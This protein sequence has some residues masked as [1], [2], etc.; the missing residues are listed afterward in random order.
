MMKLLAL[1]LLTAAALIVLP[2]RARADGSWLDSSPPAQW[3]QPGMAIPTAPAGNNLD[4]RCVA[5]TRPSETDEDVALVDAG[6]YLIGAYQGGWGVRVVLATSG[7][8][9]M[10][11]PYGFQAFVFADG[12]FAGTLS[13]DLMDSRFDGALGS[14]RLLQDGAIT[15]EFSRYADTDPLCCPSRLS[16]ANYRIDRSG[17]LPVVVPMSTSTQPTSQGG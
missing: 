1:G 13:P 15:A 5:T 4:P 11:R 12:S 16:S 9:G 6:W 7:F 2:A 17:G 10:C 8:D 14:Y 3:N